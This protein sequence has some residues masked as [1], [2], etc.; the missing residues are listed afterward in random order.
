MNTRRVLIVE[1]DPLISLELEL[2][3]AQAG[4]EICGTAFSENRASQ[5]AE[6]NKP[7]FAVI[8]V[9]LSPGDGRVVASELAARYG[10]AILFTTAHCDDT[11]DLARTGAIACLPKPYEPDDVP[12]ALQA[13]NDIQAG[14][15]PVRLPDNMRA[16]AS[17]GR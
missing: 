8:D 10:T 1:D 7:P 11:A 2:V 16:F 15:L 12:L 9:R 4:W 13:V 5:L 6:A 14:N 3:L 17:R